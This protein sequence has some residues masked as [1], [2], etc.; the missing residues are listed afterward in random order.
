MAETLYRIPV[1]VAHRR[2]ERLL[3]AIDAPPGWEHLQRKG[4]TFSPFPSRDDD[5]C[6]DVCSTLLDPHAP[7]MALGITVPSYALCQTCA[8]SIQD[9]SPALPVTDCDCPGCRP[10]G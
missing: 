9:Q 6:C 2:A 1:P 7:I 8:A 3:T 10:P 4:Q 5:W